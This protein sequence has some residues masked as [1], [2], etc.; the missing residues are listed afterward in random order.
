MK[1]VEYAVKMQDFASGTLSRLSESINRLNRDA[2]RL[3]DNA[4]KA[5]SGTASGVKDIVTKLGLATAAYKSAHFFAGTMQDALDREKL[6]ISFDILT[7]SK[8]AGKQL[9]EQLINLQK[10]TILGSEVFSGAQ[11]MLGFGFKD[12][13]VLDNMRMI[14]DISMGNVDKFNSLTLA[15]SQIRAAGKLAGQDLLQLINAGFNP[16]EQMS[17]RTGK[18]MGE[19]KEEMSRGLIT[20]EMVQQA[21]RDATGEGG[22]FNNMLATI[23]GENSGKMAQLRGAWQ[24]VKIGIGEALQ[25]IVT[26]GIEMATRLMPAI[27]RL[28]SGPMRSMARGV[29]AI[30]RGTREWLPLIGA[31]TGAIGLLTVA[32]HREAIVTGIVTT[33]TKVW[34]AAQAVVNAVMNVNPIVLIVSAVM[35][36]I[37]VIAMA[38][39]KYDEWGAAFLALLGP[40]G[41]LVNGFMAIKRNW[42][43]VVDSFKGDGILAG[44]KRIGIV[45][46]D[47]ILMPVQQLL[48][49]LSNIPG[50]GDLAGRG[51]SAIANMRRSLDLIPE[52]KRSAEEKREGDET[53]QT[54][55]MIEK[56]TAENRSSAADAVGGIQGG[57]PKVI[58]IEIGKFFDNIVFNTQGVRESAAEV[59]QI[60]LET[61][62]RALQQGATA[63]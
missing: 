35:A 61:L 28:A 52:K 25:P 20:F 37:G 56:H 4:A 9:S 36:L 47:A 13:E 7:G 63:I 16:L 1:I 23:A 41:M 18:S 54:L 40:I 5:A 57:G 49:I 10:S 12:T 48:E 27:E 21:F 50:V 34:A 17:Q 43:S 58:N 42:Q 24:E 33:A 14:G 29:T 53:L 32:I 60:V 3:N 31:L 11:T 39:K 46:L 2:S 38:I 30:V 19:L 59:E 6:Q 55:Q 44:L 22:K 26:M 62:A 51:A 15:Y 45:L 8:E